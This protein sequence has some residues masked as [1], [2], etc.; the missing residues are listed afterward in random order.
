LKIISGKLDFGLSAQDYLPELFSEIDYTNFIITTEVTI[1]SCQPK[2][3][4]GLYNIARP[5]P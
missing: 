5:F 4:V 3:L 2:R 1:S